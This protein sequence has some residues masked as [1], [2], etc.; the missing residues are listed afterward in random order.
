MVRIGANYSEGHNNSYFNEMT[1]IGRSLSSQLSG[2]GINQENDGTL[3]M[4]RDTIQNGVTGANRND[5]FKTLNT[6]KNALSNAANKT[7]IN[8]MKYVDKLLVEYKNPGKNFTAVYASSA[9]A[10]MLVDQAL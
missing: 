4:D 8:P 5:V 7:A 1:A 2:I 9:Y 3:T 6:F 10:G